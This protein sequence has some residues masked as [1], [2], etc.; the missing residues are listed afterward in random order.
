MTTEIKFM[1][2]VAKDIIGIKFRPNMTI[3]QTETLFYK[4]M[5]KYGIKEGTKDKDGVGIIC[6]NFEWTMCKTLFLYQFKFYIDL[7][8]ISLFAVPKD[9]ECY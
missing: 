8:R 1:S 3:K 2:K 7:D 4:I 6:D 5:R 9:L